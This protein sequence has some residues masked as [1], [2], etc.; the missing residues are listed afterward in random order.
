MPSGDQ[1]PALDV[2]AIRSRR[3]ETA[4]GILVPMLVGAFRAAAQ[5]HVRSAGYSV[6]MAT[7]PPFEVVGHSFRPPN[8]TLDVYSSEISGKLLSLDYG[9]GAGTYLDGTV[10]IIGWRRGDWEVALAQ[11]IVD[12]GALEFSQPPSSMLRH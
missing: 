8:L 1:K 3:R 5:K 4:L 2:A 7:F 10:A 12:S 11:A 6:S 9:R